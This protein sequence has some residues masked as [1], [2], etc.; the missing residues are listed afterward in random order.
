VTVVNVG[1]TSAPDS[2]PTTIRMYTDKIWTARY[3]AALLGLPPER[4][5][6]GADGLT[7]EDVALVV[8]TDLQVTISESAP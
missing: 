7:T 6:P 5:Q 1:N 4:V 3:L 8:G 2:A